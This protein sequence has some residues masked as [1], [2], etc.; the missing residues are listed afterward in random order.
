MSTEGQFELV[1]EEVRGFRCRVFRHA[2]RTLPD[3]LAGFSWESD[4]VCV[5]YGPLRL[6]YR[7]VSA[8]ADRLAG[9]LH[10]RY[11]V[12]PGSRV[13]LAMRNLPE[14]VDAFLA[15]GRLGAIPV[16]MNSRAAGEELAAARDGIGVSLM[17]L[18]SRCG[19]EIAA[20]PG[21]CPQVVAGD[22]T[23]E[24][25]ERQ[26]DEAG[27]ERAVQAGATRLDD[28]LASASAAPVLPPLQIAPLDPATILFTSGTT[29]RAKGAV[30]S[31]FGTCN[32]V[33]TNLYAG[34]RVAADMATRY[35]ITLQQLAAMAPQPCMLLMFPFFHT[36][37]LHTGLLST[38]AR[39][40]KVVLMRRWDAATALRL[41]EAEKVTQFPCVPTMMWDLLRSPELPG[42][43]LSSLSSVS[44][45]GQA[46]QAGLLEGMTRA[47]PRAVPGT[48]FGMTETTGA[49]AMS[50][51]EEYLSRP[52]T[53]GRV[54]ATTEI[55]ILREDGSEAERGEPGEICLRSVSNMLEYWGDREETA[56]VF[57]A[58]GF[59][60]SGDVGYVDEEGFLYIVDRK[61]DMVISAGENIYCAEVERVLLAHPALAEA[62]AFGVPD[63]RLGERLVAVVVPHA[64]AGT[65]TAEAIREHVGAHLAAY[66]VPTEVR[67]QHDSLPRNHL[68]KVDKVAMRRLHGGASTM[69]H[70]GAD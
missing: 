2:P 24:G 35:G 67:V 9:V 52:G 41:I 51:G 47:F 46:L 23:L 29:G 10:S 60:R 65:V 26:R 5:V 28:L 49:V 68:D 62:A 14:W 19:R 21:S 59:L 58:Q 55:R 20:F 45:G 1:E 36:S 34:Y 15:L 44:T 53:A 50:V 64:S 40:G 4:A 42:H 48:G 18:D 61:K 38:L 56:R 57:D 30:L 12:G 16:V 6:S 8:R 66:K 69:A 3:L 32:S 25:S 63:D 31:H 27:V 13:G 37:G 33:W 54:L 11:G 39:G 7:E 70:E 22:P 17:L 43:D